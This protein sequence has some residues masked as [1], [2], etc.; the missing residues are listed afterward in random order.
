MP[1]KAVELGPLAVGNI[2]KVGLNFVG[3]VSGLALNV[4]PSGGRSWILRVRVGKKRRDMGLGGYPDVTLAQARDAARKAREKIKAGVDPIEEQHKARELLM[5]GQA[6]A[7]PFSKAAE[8]YIETHEPGWQNA[9]HGQ[10]WRNTLKTHAYP[11]IGE[12]LV[13]DITLPHILSVLEPIW[14]TKTETAVRVRGRIERVL[15]WATVKG[16]RHGLNPARWKGHLDNLLPA[17]GK[18][19]EEE[20][21]PALPFSLVGAFIAELREERGTG[22]RALEY[23][24]LCASRSAEI[25]GAVWREIDFDEKVWTIPAKRMKIKKKEHRVPLSDAAIELL[26]AQW[27]EAAAL[28]ETGEPNRD[29][30]IFR[31][32]RGGQLSDGTLNAVID[33]MHTGKNPG[34]VDSKGRRIVQHG[35]R[36]TFR[37]WVSER[38]NYPGD[39]AEAALAHTIPDKVEAAYRRG[40][41][42]QKRRAL[43]SDWANYLAKPE[44]SAKVIEI[45]EKRAAGKE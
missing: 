22:A 31:A 10:Q 17:P 39:A 6:N 23:G 41:L 9:K 11:T 18:I 1:K 8:T 38:T 5:L 20:H 29:A 44:K 30:I 35:F 13:S 12:V 34:W 7:V 19:S 14:R 28:S 26:H 2:R 45:S 36:S 15:D 3:G 24:I 42:F 37:D 33:R 25:R 32:P 43:M 40:D 4:M 21:F 16:Y 27:N